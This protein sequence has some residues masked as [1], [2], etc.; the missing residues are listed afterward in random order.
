MEYKDDYEPVTAEK[1]ATVAPGIY[2]KDEHV[3]YVD[4]VGRVYKKMH[5]KVWHTLQFIGKH[6]EVPDSLEAWCG[7][8]C[9][10]S[11]STRYC[12]N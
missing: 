6:S 2:F 3:L 9:S 11:T 1:P 8:G 12:P 10:G 7:R 5:R 4:D